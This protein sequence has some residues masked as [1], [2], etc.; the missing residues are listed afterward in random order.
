[1]ATIGDVAR[2]AG[3]TRTTVSHALSGKRPVAP[4][5][6]ERV[7]AAVR[8]LDYRP[9]AVARSLVLRRTQTIGLSLP[10]DAHYR[11]LSDGAYLRFISAI[12]DRL[13]SHGYK[14]LCL[15]SADL[16][17][18]DLADL[19]R[20]GHVDGVL[21]LELHLDDPRVTALQEV[22]LPF[23]AIGRPLDTA[24]LV[25][26]DADSVQATEDAVRYLFGLGHRRIAFL[27]DTAVQSFHH[28][29]MRG[30]YRAHED[31]GLSVE[32]AQFLT[33][34]PE[35]SLSDA[36]APLLDPASDV[37]ALLVVSDHHTLSVL[38]ILAE[39]GRRVP[40]DLSVFALC[41]SPVMPLSHPPITALTLPVDRMS[42]TAVDV[43]IEM[44]AGRPPRQEAHILPFG[45]MV[46]R[47]SVRRAGPALLAPL[48]TSPVA[49]ILRKER[50][51]TV[52]APAA[53]ERRHDGIAEGGPSGR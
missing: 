27:G 12:A 9:N 52:E 23:V 22:G 47:R 38:H 20:D 44:L 6:R 51:A 34:S 42:H 50:G 40:D 10:I 2:L 25:H 17:V 32:P 43:L 30:F 36:L 11:S 31:Y 14:L 21:L 39:H 4:A 8:A 1:M 33:L 15:I 13:S 28:R 3:V 5:T 35:M 19:A 49:S 26:V 46:V 18:T 7:L 53:P 24:G 37:T 16:G 48:G 29:A 45:E 41:D